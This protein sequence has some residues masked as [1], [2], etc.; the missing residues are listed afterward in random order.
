[1][2]EKDKNYISAV[3]YLGEEEACVKPFLAELTARLAARFEKYELVFVNDASKDGTPEAVRSFLADMEA[4]PP[5]TMLHMSLRHSLELAMNAGVDIAIG[6]FVYEFD[7]M[8]M[9]WPADSIEKAYETCI[10]GSDIVAVSPR[11]NRGGASKLFYKLF[12]ASSGSRYPLRTEAFRILSRRAINRVRA[13][14]G[15]VPYR[16][17]AYAACGLRLTHIEYE[18]AAG[19]RNEALR[20]ARAADALAMYTDLAF[21]I[22]VGIAMVMLSLMLL[23][24]VYTAVV[25]LGPFTKPSPGW[26]TTMLVVTGGFAGVFLIQAV[27]LK[28]LSLLVELVFKKQNYLVE[29]VEK[30]V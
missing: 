12:N 10:A 6:D 7:S 27:I 9:P 1:M 5:V 19:G 17:A 11:Q 15:T 25:F 28:Y 23:A 21:K 24:V 3:V 20:G 30:I 26:T 13:V 29:S 2:T 16:K 14:S 22:S 4:A 18:G 8:Q